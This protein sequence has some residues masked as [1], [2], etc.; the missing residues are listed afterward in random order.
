[1]ADLDETVHWVND[2]FENVPMYLIEASMKEDVWTTY[3]IN[4]EN[5]FEEFTNNGV[6]YPMWSTAFYVNAS[7]LSD[8]IYENKEDICKLGF[9]IM[10][11][12]DMY[13]IYLGIDGAGYDFYEA[14]W[15]PLYDYFLNK[16]YK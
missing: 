2:V 14:H 5:E 4:D 9:V 8:M 3:M 12:E 11:N 15:M 1:M 6:Y 10:Y 13:D 16:L 7:Y